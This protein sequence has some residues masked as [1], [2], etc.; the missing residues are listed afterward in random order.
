MCEWKRTCNHPN[1]FW[2]QSIPTQHNICACNRHLAMCVND[3]AKTIAQ[4]IDD[5]E[6]PYAKARRVETHLRSK[7][8]NYAR[9]TVK[10]MFEVH[11]NG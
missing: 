6:S 4:T 9:I 8:N 5:Q 7:Y 3:M 1:T 2:V 11:P 10:P